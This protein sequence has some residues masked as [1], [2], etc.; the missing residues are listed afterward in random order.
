MRRLHKL[1][2]ATALATV[3]TPATFGLDLEWQQTENIQ[4]GWGS[5]SP[6]FMASNDGGVSG[7]SPIT[8]YLR[9][10]ISHHLSDTTRFSYGFGLDVVAG[11]FSPLT[12]EKW[13]SHGEMYTH[14]L[15][16][17]YQTIHQLYGELK[18]RSLYLMVGMKEYDRSLFNSELGVG[19]YVL[20]RNARP[21]PQARA[22][23]FDFVN[24]PFTNGW[25]QIQGELAYGKFIDDDWVK[26]QYNNYNSHIA[27]NV[28]FH[29]KR[30][31][32]RSNP[33][34]PFSVTVGM[35]HAAQFGG[36]YRSYY[37]GRLTGYTKNH[38]S[39]KDFAKIL[40]PTEN[41]KPGEYYDGNS[42]GS[43]D[44]DFRYRFGDGSELHAFMQHP[45]EDGSGIGFQNG[46][47]GIYGLQYKA[48]HKG[49]ID[50]AMVQ[51]VDFMNQ[52]GPM[53]WYPDENAGT[54][55]TSGQ[56]TGADH[57]YY[58]Y[59][60]TGWSNYGMMIGTPFISSPIYN[61]DGFPQTVNNRI[62]G[63]Q[64]GISGTPIP[65]LHYKVLLGYKVSWGTYYDRADHQRRSTSA[66]F[67]LDWRFLRSADLRLNASV[68]F[69][70]GN[71]YGNN[72]A[73]RLGLIY[74]MPFKL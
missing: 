45:W 55:V 21:I 33:Q 53:H 30:L 3:G 48:A 1:L 36:I 32:L 37:H 46:F 28:W 10:K 62:R 41:S 57:Y 12:Y 42:L 16:P 2:L 58:N 50:E 4:A 40:I 69:D 72:F 51:Y 20:S 15:G 56:A 65:T 23:F 6:Y 43:W 29:H 64:A 61:L 27:T 25:L 7:V 34:Q 8:A 38:I 49:W 19:D 68:A 66:L 52:S 44:V 17:G 9:S 70:T 39:F 73:Y 60:Y 63:F 74:T 22:G 24:V 71:L 18:Y 47:D 5:Y 14:R 13:N 26:S 54:G 67:G 35:Q 59:F 11:Y 31:Y